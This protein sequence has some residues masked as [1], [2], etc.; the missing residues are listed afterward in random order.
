MV[1]RAAELIVSNMKLPPRLKKNYE[2]A[3]VFRHGKRRPGQYLTLHYR[4]TKTG[5]IRAGFTTIKHYGNAV[6]RNRM[7][8]LMREALR[9]LAPEIEEGV[10]IILMGHRAGEALGFS[11]IREDLR[12]LLHKEKLLVDRRAGTRNEE[13]AD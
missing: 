13:T 3:R 12:K 8:R 5:T 11:Q 7:R 6:Q 9:D 1:F 10:D 4:R 2:F